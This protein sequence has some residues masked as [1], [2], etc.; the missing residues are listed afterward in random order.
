MALSKFERGVTASVLDILDQTEKEL[1]ITLADRLDTLEGRD[2]A[3]KTV[4]ARLNVLAN[5]VGKIRASAFDDAGSVWDDSMSGLAAAE[6]AYLDQHLQKISPVQLD[7]VLP[8]PALLAAIVTTQPMQGRVLADWAQGIQQAD[9]QR[10]MDTVRIGMVQGDTTDNIVRSVVGSRA[11]D[12]TDGVLQMTRNDIAS[13]TQTAVATVSNEARQA[14]YEA[15]NDIFTQEQ[16]VATLDDATCIE[17]GDLDGEVFDIGDGD[18]PPLHFNC[19]CVRVPVIDGGSVGDRPANAA[20]A[21][22]LDGLNATDRAARVSELVG[23]V[24]TTTTYSDWLTSQTAAFQDHVLGPS[25]GALFRDGGLSLSKFV[26]T[27]GDNL[28]LDQLRTLE[29]A[30][31]SKAGL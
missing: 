19:R 5:A 3:G 13:V 8:D 22:E 25:R 7:T 17:C 4:A 23:T 15:N 24:P 6:P 14:Y 31:F 16:W 12:G 1:R 10:I 18:Q 29:P 2:I 11:L 28:N 9:L 20:Y 21:D 30:A 27:S 26:N